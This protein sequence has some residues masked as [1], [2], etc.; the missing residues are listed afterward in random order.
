MRLSV[1]PALVQQRVATR[2]FVELV[3]G[4]TLVQKVRREGRLPPLSP[5]VGLL[6]TVWLWTAFSRVDP[7]FAYLIPALHSIQY[8]YFVWLLRRNEAR[9]H[10]G[11]PEF[12]SVAR[13]LVMLALGAV[14]LG[15][16]SSAASRASS[17]T[18]WS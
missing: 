12:R 18:C 15:W 9:A 13:S 11:P 3:I 16:L 7:L 10:A 1:I 8:L 2:T 5:L 6:V 14:I 17:T 4:A